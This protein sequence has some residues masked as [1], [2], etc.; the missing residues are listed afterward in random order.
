MEDYLKAVDSLTINT[1]KVVLQKQ[2]VEL[3]GKSKDNEYIIK[4]ITMRI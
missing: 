3:K 1:D 2:V 4:A